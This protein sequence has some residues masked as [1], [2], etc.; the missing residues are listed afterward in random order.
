MVLAGCSSKPC[1]YTKP[2]ALI[3]YNTPEKIKLSVEYIDDEQYINALENALRVMV[4][5]N[6]ERLLIIKAYEKQIDDY[7]KEIK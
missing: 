7:N 3:K 2:K 1:V 6:K 5:G 4:V